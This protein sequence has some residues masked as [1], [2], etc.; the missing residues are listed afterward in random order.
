VTPARVRRCL[1]LRGLLAAALLTVA[2]GASAEPPARF[3]R[4][5][6]NEGLSQSTVPAIL[7][8]HVGFLWFGTDEGLNR[9]DG[10]SFVVFKNDP[11]SP[12][13][14]PDNNVSA[15]LEDSQKRLWVAT[16]N[17]LSLFDRRS[18]TFQS[19]LA[20][21]TG[22]WSVVE[23]AN[24]TLWAASVGDG[25]YHVDPATGT[26]VNVRH[27]AGDPD[28]LASDQLL[29][30]HFD[31]RGRLWVGTKDA[32]VER[33]DGTRFHHY[34]HR[35]GDTSSLGHDEVWGLAEDARG[36]LWVATY[37]GGV[38]VLDTES[39]RFR[40]YT[41]RAGDPHS[42]RTE[43]TTCVFIDRE[44]VAWVGTDGGGLHRYD[45]TVDGFESFVHAPAD[46][47]SISRDV[48]RAIRE[49]TRGQI[50]VG[51]FMGGVNVLRRRASAFDFYKHRASDPTS[52][53][54]AAVSAFLEDREGRIWVGTEGGTVERFDPDRGTFTRYRF[55]SAHTRG[56]SVMALHQ[57]RQGRIWVGTYRGGLARFEPESGRFQVY[58]PASPASALSD[59]EVWA[60]AEDDAG[61]WVGTNADLDRFD[62]V[63]GVV[64]HLSTAD[65][66]GRRA[67]VRA[68]HVDRAGN[69]WIGTFDGLHLL[70]KDTGAVVRYRHDPGD[71][72]SIS[73]DAVVAFHE[74]SQG[75]LWVGTFG[76][77]LNR[78]DPATGTFTV[79][80]EAQGLPSD[81]VYGIVEDSSG[82]LWISTNRGLSRFDPA[83][84][85]FENFDR[86][87]GLESPQFHM[88]ARLRLRNGRILFGSVDGLCSFDPGAVKADTFEPPVVLTSFRIFGEPAPLPAAISTLDEVRLT[89]GDKVFSLEFAALDYAIPRRNRYAYTLEGFSDQWIELGP[90]REVSFTNLDPGA[91]VL[92]VK[93]TNSDGAW[94]QSQTSLRVVVAP[95]IWRTWWFRALAATA[96][97]LALVGLHRLRVRRLKQSE[98]ELKT[99]VEEALGRVRILRGLIPMCAWC[100]KIRDDQGYWNQVE[101]FISQRTEADFSHG[102]CPEC[103]RE[104]AIERAVER[105]EAPRS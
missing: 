43:L 26:V 77:G 80:R 78:F 68:L 4:L 70:R 6:V 64:G 97:V 88:G 90:R 16:S 63:R 75:R 61:L 30:L 84:G 27:D 9:F 15:L 28:S 62:P 73:H 12:G 1:F 95:P 55:P 34:R 52:L 36:Q 8:D 32:G 98:R 102:I 79:F 48:V 37:G 92:R 39:G 14:L 76:G 105:S 38:S 3:V 56:P 24:G 83:S 13:S 60:L 45:A 2:R 46:P 57:D 99:R 35:P 49:D 22:V 81:V 66:N 65:E 91:Y 104:L 25:L 87:N 31:R 71:P 47:D 96:V 58:R 94:S 29:A 82:R 42:L 93:A 41:Q 54:D 7:Q 69:L 103:V 10:Y 53:G 85:H 11:R 5:S 23:G 17:G 50:W 59:G 19:V 18:E 21:R 44:G 100:K 86:S 40:R 89:P 33:M 51:T 74:D 67:G 101:T 72:R 20:N